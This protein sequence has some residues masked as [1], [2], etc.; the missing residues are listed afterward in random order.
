MAAS[1]L[2]VDP[3]DIFSIGMYLKS[4]QNTA[5]TLAYFYCYII[6]Q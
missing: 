1:S 4:S 2:E 5:L 6:I 3:V